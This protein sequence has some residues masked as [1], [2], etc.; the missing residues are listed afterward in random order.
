MKTLKNTVSFSP[1]TVFYTLVLNFLL[2]FGIFF[3]PLIHNVFAGSILFLSPFIS[4]S[5]L[6]LL[7]VVLVKKQKLEKDLRKYL[8]L[9]GVSAAGV[10]PSMLAHN[11]I[12]GVS[13]YF[14]GKEFEDPISFL[15]G[16]LVLPLIF[17]FSAIKSALLLRKKQT[18]QI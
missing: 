10:F 12:Y 2:I 7:L 14:T 11:L 8:L 17:I 13:V 6:G 4:F 16:I 3:I 15:L 1:P 9:T 5:I 18:K